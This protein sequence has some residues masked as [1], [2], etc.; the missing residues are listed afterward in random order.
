MSVNRNLSR[1]AFSLI[2]LLIVILIIG[3]VYT[4]A[5]TSFAKAGEQSLHISL[6]NLREYLQSLQHEKS[7]KFL[8]L[9]DC[10]SCD[11]IV[12]G[13]IDET[14]KGSFDKFI[15]SSIKVYRYDSYQ[16]VAEIT[17]EVYFNSEDVEEDVCFSYTVDVRGIGEQVFVE[18]NKK[19]YDYSSYFGE[20][21]IFDSV[22][23][24]VDAKET[25]MTEVIR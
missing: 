12:D 4:M 20:T 8:C 3:V 25:L 1:Y 11:I 19:V 18:F 24:L 6:V 10:S 5:I 14:L 9:D 17:N 23:E 15:D 22:E 2:E 13:E 16:G 7:V 21:P